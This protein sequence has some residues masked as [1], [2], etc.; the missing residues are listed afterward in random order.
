MTKQKQTLRYK[1]QTSG[2]QW[3]QEIWGKYGGYNSDMGESESLTVQ[4]VT[5]TVF[6]PL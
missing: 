6:P 1:G 5:L 2:Y 3:E 4:I